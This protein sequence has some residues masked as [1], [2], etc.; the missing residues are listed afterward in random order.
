MSSLSK[1]FLPLVHLRALWWRIK[2]QIK[3]KIT[4]VVCIDKVPSELRIVHFDAQTV[5]VQGSSHM[6]LMEITRHLQKDSYAVP[7][8]TSRIMKN[9]Y[10]SPNNLLLTKTRKIIKESSSTDNEADYFTWHPLFNL[11]KR[12]IKGCCTSL[13]TLHNNYY[14]SLVD[15]LP[16]LF[17]LHSPC[18]ADRQIT[19][20]LPGGPTP[21]ESFFLEKLCPE[22]VTIQ[23]VQQDTL[24]SCDEFLFVDFLS[25]RFAGFLPQVYLT[26]FFE[27][28]L[29]KRPRQKNKKIYISRKKAYNNRHVMNE[30]ALV[31][32]LLPL[33][34]KMYVLEDLD[35]PSQIDLFFDAESIVS[36]HGAGLTNLLFSNNVQVLELHP[37][38]TLFP[39]YYFMCQSLN[40]HYQYWCGTGETRHSN[41]TVDVDSVL[42]L[43]K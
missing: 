12:H 37:N 43:L 32:A 41:F 31:E 16:R 34:Y 4:R 15:N 30:D 24:Y 2:Q 35:L 29:P 27:K 1:K 21:V 38:Q 17:L 10:Y 7:A 18:Y 9:V 26:F 33:G 5:N 42:A 6:P 23:H 3:R 11:E 40:H 39:H 36:P 20:L 8:G 25:R 22:N 13:R 28:V 14:H 19:L